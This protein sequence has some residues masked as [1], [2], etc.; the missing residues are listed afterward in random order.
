MRA[1]LFISRCVCVCRKVSGVNRADAP[2][3]PR[4]TT[5]FLSQLLSTMGQQSG[6]GQRTGESPELSVDVC[7]LAEIVRKTG[8]AIRETPL[9]VK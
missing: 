8:G 4:L 2:C 6:G 9:R 3:D 7:L 1:T 5:C